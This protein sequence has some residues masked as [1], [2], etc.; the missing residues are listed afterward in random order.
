MRRA[1]V[2]RNPDGMVL[3]TLSTNE[4]DFGQ[5]VDDVDLLEMGREEILRRGLIKATDGVVTYS[6]QE[7][8]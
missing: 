2:G 6:V 3:A 5:A 7:I 8:E 4:L 1:I